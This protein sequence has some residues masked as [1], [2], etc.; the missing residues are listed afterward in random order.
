M[1]DC[2]GELKSLYEGTRK[3]MRDYGDS[4]KQI[5]FTEIGCPGVREPKRRLGWWHGKGPDEQQQA[6]WVGNI[7]S[8]CLEWEGIEKI[9]WAFFRDTDRHFKSA[10][11]YFGLV[12]NDFSKKPAYEIY[13]KLSKQW[14]YLSEQEKRFLSDGREDK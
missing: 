3:I 1:E 6:L 11:D 9:F 12:R 7:Y 10:V 14:Q 5:W 8:N 4:D 2:V 13:R